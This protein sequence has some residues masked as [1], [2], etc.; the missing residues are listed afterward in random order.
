MFFLSSLLIFILV[1]VYAQ[2]VNTYIPERAYQYLPTLKSEAERIFPQGPDVAY[3]GSLIELES[4]L[5]LTHKR[6][7][8][9]TSQLKT[10]REEGA[11]LVQITKAFKADG[12]V[13]FD[14][15][16]EM[17]NNY[18]DELKELSWENVYSRPDLQLRVGI[19]LTKE[20]WDKLFMV[21]NHEGR[22]GMT[23][24]AYNGG[25]RDV[26]RARI[27]CGLKANCDPQLWFGHVELMSPKSTKP[28]YGTRSAKDINLHHVHGV[29]KVR[30]PK[31]QK[32]FQSKGG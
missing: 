16:T 4:C 3:Y 12:S 18:K 14:K 25:I 17:A 29:L 6:C 8:S 1:P 20:N 28:L 27:A 15:L 5:S 13:R 22:L 23:D 30:L 24:S 26:N 11:G 7:W 31:Y 21:K 10:Q 19:L 9:P 32:Y 2:D